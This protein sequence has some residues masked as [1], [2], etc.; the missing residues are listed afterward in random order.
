MTEPDVAI[1][2]Y[3]LA[4]ECAAFVWLLYRR[5]PTSRPM[6]NSFALFF[7][8]TAAAA[9]AGGTVHGF[10]LHPPSLAGD[11]LWRITLLAVGFSAFA[12][13]SLFALL[14]FTPRVSNVIRALAA[15]ELVAYA[16]LVLSAKRSFRVAIADYVPPAVILFAAFLIL[17]VRR[18][19][20]ALLAGAAGL[21]LGIAASYLQQRHAGIHPVYFNHN[22]VYHLLQAVAFLLVFRTARPPRG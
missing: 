1:T 19:D 4:L 13:W 3:L 18:R 21:A 10:F 2:D 8:A 17:F 16:V 11:L 6:R 22:A 9:I 15:I 20:P 14:L 12:L 7:A 5:D